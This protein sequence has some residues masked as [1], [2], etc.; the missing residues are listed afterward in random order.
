LAYFDKL[1][2][3]ISNVVNKT[4]FSQYPHLDTSIMT[5]EA[6]SNFNS[7]PYV[8]HLGSSIS[9]PVPKS[10]RKCY[11]EAG[12]SGDFIYALHC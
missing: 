3:M 9:Q 5:M 1:S 7:K 8:N 10:N 2:A 12:A 11:T 4:W 6:N